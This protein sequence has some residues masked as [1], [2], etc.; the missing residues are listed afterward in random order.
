MEDNFASPN[1]F[2]TQFSPRR[3]VTKVVGFLAPCDVRPPLLNIPK[4]VRP[5]LM[6]DL[7]RT[8]APG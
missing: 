4:D 7:P 1:A 8:C 6:S 3:L 5:Y 2:F